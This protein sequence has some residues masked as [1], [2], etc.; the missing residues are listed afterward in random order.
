VNRLAP[1]LDAR[2]I[3]TPETLALYSKLREADDRSV[4]DVWKEACD[5]RGFEVAVLDFYEMPSLLRLLWVEPDWA[6]VFVDAGAIVFVKRRGPNAA[7]ARTLERALRA[8]IVTAPTGIEDRLGNA[9]LRF[10]DSPQPP[11][12]RRLRFPYDAFYRANF[13]LQ[14]RERAGARKAYLDL[15]ETEE[16]SLWASTHRLDIFGNLVWCLPPEESAAGRALCE[17]LDD[18]SWVPPAQRLNLLF[19]DV[20][21][22]ITADSSDPQIETIARRITKH[23][24]AT[25][26]QKQWAWAQVAQAKERAA[27]WDGVV[28]ALRNANA[29]VATTPEMW[30]SL[31]LVL[32]LRLGRSGEAIAAYRKFQE[33]GGVDSLVTGR[34]T[35]LAP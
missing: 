4:P 1:F 10:L 31:G 24:E 29:A 22:R 35:E 21:A 3:G 2:W 17:A 12:W 18:E 34:L 30:R 23:P 5:A 8:E 11:I 28:E 32:D 33:L 25:P 13:A 15:F 16:G 14:V 6:P 20:N 27:D 7:L 26:E 19:R 9:V